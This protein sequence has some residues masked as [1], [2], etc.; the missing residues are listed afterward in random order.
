MPAFSIDDEIPAAR[1]SQ[2]RL[3]VDVHG[4]HRRSRAPWRGRYIPSYA[5]PSFT[6]LVIQL[7]V[8]RQEGPWQALVTRSNACCSGA[9]RVWRYT[10]VMAE[11]VL[12]RCILPPRRRF[13]ER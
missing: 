13:G 3:L 11:Q 7:R 12:T 8:A 2:L 4:R 5:I 10:L 6:S 1:R 9:A